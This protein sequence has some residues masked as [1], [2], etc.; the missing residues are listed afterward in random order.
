MKEK[1]NHLSLLCYQVREEAP[2]NQIT[3][4]TAPEEPGFH[5]P[6]VH[7]SCNGSGTYYVAPRSVWVEML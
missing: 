2:M 5:A 3:K 4:A 7:R 1:T 6:A